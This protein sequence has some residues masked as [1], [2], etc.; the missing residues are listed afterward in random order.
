MS[1]KA[2]KD[3]SGVECIETNCKAKQHKMHFCSTH[4]A[5]FKFGAIKKDGSHPLDYEKK[6][7]HFAR[8]N[9]KVE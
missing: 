9:K 7:E 5:E 1:T 8:H 3:P 4:Y 6:L 2:V